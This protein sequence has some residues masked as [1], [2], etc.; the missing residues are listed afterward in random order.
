MPLRYSWL[1]V[2][3]GSDYFCAVQKLLKQELGLESGD[4][5]MSAVVSFDCVE[6][7]T[8]RFALSKSEELLLLGVPLD[9]MNSYPAETPQLRFSRGPQMRKM[10][11]LEAIQGVLQGA[12]QWRQLRWYWRGGAP[13][14]PFTKLCKAY[15]R[16]ISSIGTS[17]RCMSAAA[18]PNIDARSAIAPS[19]SLP[20]YFFSCIHELD[21]IQKTIIALPEFIARNLVQLTPVL[22]IFPVDIFCFGCFIG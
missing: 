14:G 21:A 20:T 19:I 16:R 7:A 9:D 10:P 5:N 1:E 15:L 8:H 22:Y 2:P 12:H 4:F 3:G 18:E 6:A 17:H 13:L 11:V